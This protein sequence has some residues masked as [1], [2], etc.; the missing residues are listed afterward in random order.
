MTDDGA[1]QLSWVA[2]IENA[3][4]SPS[5]A[6]ADADLEF[7]ALEIAGKQSAQSLVLGPNVNLTGRNE[8]RLAE[9]STLTVDQGTVSS[10]RWIDIHPRATLTG[11]GSIDAIVYNRGTVAVAGADEP[12]LKLGGDYHQSADAN[13]RLTLTRSDD[14]PIVIA[15]DASLAGTL[16]L[17][18]GDAFQL[19]SGKPNVV[20]KA[21]QVTG[22]FANVDD[23]VVVDDGR[24][25]HIRYT[26]ASVSLS[27]KK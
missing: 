4:D 25:F 18:I 7:L 13:L 24:R 14:P 27:A 1:P 16:T 2:R 26:D 5:T 6:R 9:N 21:S 3:S 8:I 10:L 19:A 20:L 23:E 17:E 22:R 12:K 11:S 15:G